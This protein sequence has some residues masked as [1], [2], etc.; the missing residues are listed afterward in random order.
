MS[1]TRGKSKK[2]N[3]IKEWGVNET[4]KKK[5]KK[6]NTEQVIYFQVRRQQ[7]DLLLGIIIIIITI[8]L[9][10]IHEVVHTRLLSICFLCPLDSVN[11]NV[12]ADATCFFFRLFRAIGGRNSLLALFLSILPISYCTNY[13]P[14]PYDSWCSPVVGILMGHHWAA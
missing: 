11:P 2:K 10:T 12:M 13:C 1:R 4:N 9:S 14:F 7:Q 3:K 5:K 8:V 6:E